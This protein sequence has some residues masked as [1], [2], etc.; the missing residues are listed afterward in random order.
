MNNL[1][2]ALLDNLISYAK[3]YTNFYDMTKPQAKQ[4]SA[5][6]TQ[7]LEQLKDSLQ[8]QTK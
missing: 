5:G 3:D 1:Q 6:F 2:E 4:M 7:L 8:E